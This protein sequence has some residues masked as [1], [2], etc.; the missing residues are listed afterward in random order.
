VRSQL[1]HISIAVVAAIVASSCV[2][3][4]GDGDKTPE[5]TP[6]PPLPTAE[7]VIRQW[8]T[9]NRNVDYVGDCADAQQGIDVGKIC[10]TLVGTRGR[11]RAYNLGPT[12]SEYTTTMLLEE[13]ADAGWT[14]L[15]IRNRDP[16]APIPGI[17]WPL[18]QGDRVVFVGLGEDDCLSIREQPSLQGARTICMPDG[19]EAIILEGPVDAD[20]FTW[21]RVA[22]DGFN[23]WAVGI[24]MRLPEAIADL[25]ATPSPE[26][27]R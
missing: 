19:T 18:Q 8:V 11:N 6:T 13:S 7:D 12:F 16:N 21:W 20:T 9:D 14:V 2:F 3:G 5:P 10:S 25:F 26:A 24:Y 17:E 23:G 4:G 22:G 15:W 27:D 1:L